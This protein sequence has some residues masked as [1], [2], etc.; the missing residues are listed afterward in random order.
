MK[1]VAPFPGIAAPQRRRL[2]VKVLAGTG[3]PD[4][5]DRTAVALR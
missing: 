4:E 5:T 2:F 1:G 3:R